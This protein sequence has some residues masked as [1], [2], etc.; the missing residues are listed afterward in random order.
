MIISEKSCHVLQAEEVGCHLL[1]VA[2]RRAFFLI[3]PRLLCHSLSFKK[4]RSVVRKVFFFHANKF[5][6][7]FRATG[8]LEMGNS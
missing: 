7:W 5:I 4:V 2:V 6:I 8:S 3:L 1:H